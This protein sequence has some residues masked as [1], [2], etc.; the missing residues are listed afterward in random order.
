MKRDTFLYIIYAIQEIEKNKQK[1]RK[2]TK[3]W[4]RQKNLEENLRRKPRRGRRKI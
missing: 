2:I 1:W 3:K 4:K